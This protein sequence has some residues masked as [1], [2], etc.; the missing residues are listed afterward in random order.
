[1]ENRAQRRQA[2]FNNSI[3]P[4]S[5]T[6]NSSTKETV[7]KTSIWTRVKAWV[8]GTAKKVASKARIVLSQLRSV[9]G[10]TVAEVRSNRVVKAIVFVVPSVT[11]FLN[12]V[13]AFIAI[14]FSITG[15]VI[16]PLQTFA[17]LAAAY[18]AFKAMAW[19]VGKLDVSARRGSRVANIVLDIADV[20]GHAV[21]V[22]L[23]A[24]AGALVLANF[25]AAGPVVGTIQAIIIGLFIALDV[26]D[27]KDSL[28]RA[29]TVDELTPDFP[30]SAPVIP[31]SPEVGV[32]PFYHASMR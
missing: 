16:A 23:Q 3:T 30:R 17:A 11:R 15:L 20:I 5:I 19:A 14:A 31:V 28:E 6:P 27:R 29:Q 22:V 32:D 25:I 12:N 18:I 26:Q 9:L 4:N 13:L 10:R 24:A 8:S 2:K 21:T 1:M 7:M